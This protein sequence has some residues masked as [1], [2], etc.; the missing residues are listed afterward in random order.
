MRTW[1]E[2]VGTAVRQRP[3]PPSPPSPAQ[4]LTHWPTRQRQ[5]T[6]QD[7]SQEWE[8]IWA[9]RST[10]HRRM[11]TPS[12]TTTPGPRLTLGPMLQFSPIRALGSWGQRGKPKWATC[13]PRQRQSI[14]GWARASPPARCPQCQGL[15][16]AAQDASVAVT[17]GRGTC[18]WGNPWAARCPSRS[19]QGENASGGS[20]QPQTTP[21]LWPP[22]LTLQLHGIELPFLGHDREDL[23]L[24]GRG[25]QLWEWAAREQGHGSGGLSHP[26]PPSSWLLHT[27]M[28]C[29]TEGLR[30][31]MP[32]LILLDT[33][34]CGFST[35]RWMRP[36]SASHT[37]TPYLEGS[38]TLVTWVQGD[39]RPSPVLLS[40]DGHTV[41]NFPCF[42]PSA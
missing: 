39:V 37:T 25:P 23:L 7:S 38:S 12:S 27:W 6:I 2:E 26:S 3:S 32:A 19:L 8:R 31:Y 36:V 35:N 40:L 30:I 21:T 4:R 42:V 17:V 22:R 20:A 29:S 1:G 14:M 18:Q 13:P 34:T 11:H 28:R 10:V 5:P 9:S 33:N 16:T 41:L 24:N 15:S